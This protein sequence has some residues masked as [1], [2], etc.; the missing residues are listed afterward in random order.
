M[1]SAIQSQLLLAFKQREKT[2]GEIFRYSGVSA[3]GIVGVPT[4]E[5]QLAQGGPVEKIAAVLEVRKSWFASPPEARDG[6]DLAVFAATGAQVRTSIVAGT[7]APA[8]TAGA[9]V[10][11]YFVT[12]INADDPLTYL[13]TLVD[14]N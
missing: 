3:V 14:R 11:Q 12:S 13:F 8:L 2:D 10:R 9:P 1:D 6:E 4:I 7:V 5:A